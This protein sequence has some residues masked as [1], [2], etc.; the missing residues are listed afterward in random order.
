MINELPSGFAMALAQHPK[1]MEAFSSLPQGEQQ[2]LLQEEI[3]R[4]HV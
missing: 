3:G 1:A 2:K 4:A